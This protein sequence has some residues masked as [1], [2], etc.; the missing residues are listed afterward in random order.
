MSYVK[1]GFKKDDFVWLALLKR[2]HS[3]TATLLFLLSF[4]LAGNG[5]VKDVK[6]ISNLDFVHFPLS[7]NNP[8]R[9]A[10]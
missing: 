2:H 10:G 8:F 7:H 6:H 9:V 5:E 1:F 4:I 3:I